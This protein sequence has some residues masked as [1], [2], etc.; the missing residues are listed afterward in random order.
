[1]ITR[2]RRAAKRDAWLKRIV[3]FT[4]TTAVCGNMANPA[5]SRDYF[6]PALLETGR[7]GQQPVDLSVFENGNQVPGK[8]RVDIWVNDMLM[9]T[10]DVRFVIKPGGDDKAGLQPCLT[11]R[12]YNGSA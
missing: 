12:I 4:A 1:M 5:F 3:L 11:G 2:Q 10:R 6:N 8:Y 9:E 7:S